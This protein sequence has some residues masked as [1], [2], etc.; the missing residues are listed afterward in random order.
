M[1][2][3]ERNSIKDIGIPSIR[4]TN[5][6]SSKVLSE[7]VLGDDWERLRTEGGGGQTEEAGMLQ[8]MGLQRVRHD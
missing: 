3:R 6:M 5:L 2:F 8:S 7:S 1:V 4:K